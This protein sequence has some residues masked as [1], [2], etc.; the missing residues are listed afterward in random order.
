MNLQQD[1]KMRKGTWN[2]QDELPIRAKKKG[3]TPNSRL[4]LMWSVLLPTGVAVVVEAKLYKDD[5]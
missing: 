4:R 5:I 3:R 2:E 1:N